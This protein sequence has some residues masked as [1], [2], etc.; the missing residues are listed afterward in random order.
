[1]CGAIR[2]IGGAYFLVLWLFV[3]YLKAKKEERTMNEQKYILIYNDKKCKIITKND[4][5]F[6]NLFF[7]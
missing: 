2:A 3:C 5:I 1:M 7:A 4:K 6:E